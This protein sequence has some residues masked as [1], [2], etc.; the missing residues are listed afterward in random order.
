MPVSGLTQPMSVRGKRWIDPVRAPD[1]A[2][3]KGGGESHRR[4]SWA[5]SQALRTWPPDPDGAR[6]GHARGY[7][8][9]T[10]PL[11]RVPVGHGQSHSATPPWWLQVPRRCSL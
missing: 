4:C 9:P 2:A 11:D 7:S 10:G 8:G 1:E 3:P 5:R 6:A